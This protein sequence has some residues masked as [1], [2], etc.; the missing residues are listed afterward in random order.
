MSVGYGRAVEWDGKI[1]TGSVVVNGVTTKVTADRAII[2][3]YAAG[4]SDALSWEIDRFRIEIFEKLMP[5]L[6]RQNS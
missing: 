3:A 4:F 2:H 5:F 6:L 1:L